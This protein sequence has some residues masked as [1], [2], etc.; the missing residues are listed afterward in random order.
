MVVEQLI[1]VIRFSVKTFLVIKI[2]IF[3]NILG[4]L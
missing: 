2:C 3:T 4:L 1:Q